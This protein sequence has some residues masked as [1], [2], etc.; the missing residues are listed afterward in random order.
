MPELQILG[1]G[2]GTFILANVGEDVEKG[3]LLFISQDGTWKRSDASNP[4]KMPV[5]GLA[6]DNIKAEL[7]GRILIFGV[8]SQ[9]DWTWSAGYVLYAGLQPGRITTTKPNHDVNQVQVIG[10]TLNDGRFIFFHPQDESEVGA[11]MVS[12]PPQGANYKQV[13]NL[14]IEKVNGKP[15]LTVEY[16]D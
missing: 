6:M 2:A 8:F 10:A 13:T 15:K 3:D 7:K 16:N 9:P 12:V 14:F 1:K 5:R 11:G 4:D